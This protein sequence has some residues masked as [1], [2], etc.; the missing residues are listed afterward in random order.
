MEQW[1]LKVFAAFGKYDVMYRPY[2]L[3]PLLLQS[4][5]LPYK[6]VHRPPPTCFSPHSHINIHSS[7]RFAIC[8]TALLPR[9]HARGQLEAV[10]R[11]PTQTRAQPRTCLARVQ[12]PAISELLTKTK[13][14]D[15]MSVVS[16]VSSHALIPRLQDHDASLRH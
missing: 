15:A 12:L 9:H 8:Y 3:D 5:T 14:Q 10:L 16:E 7:T 4:H 11:L 1:C 2:L 13:D 6:P